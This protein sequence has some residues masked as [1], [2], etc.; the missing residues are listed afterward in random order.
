M[1]CLDCAIAGRDVPA[2]GICQS[3]GGG[4]CIS[5]I[6]F[7]THVLAGVGSPGPSDRHATRLVTCESCAP[8]IETMH[9]VDYDASGAI[10][11]N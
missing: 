8:V 11:G 5:G 10:P 4:V 6:Q 3:C 9:P 2:V 1:N 7:D